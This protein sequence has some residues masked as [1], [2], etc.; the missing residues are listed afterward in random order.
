MSTGIPAD[1]HHQHRL[2]AHGALRYVTPVA[3][4]LMGLLFSLTGLNGFLH[5]LPE[6]DP[7]TF[8]AGVSAF[9]G[10]LASS[11]YMLELISGTQLLVGIL[12]VINLFVPLALVL[13]APVVVNIIAFHLFLM[14]AGTGLALVVVAMEVYL[15]W[16]YR[17]TYRPMLAA[18]TRPTE[19]DQ[20]TSQTG[21]IG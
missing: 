8:P 14:P 5:F 19:V 15:V 7:S 12:L 10:G 18:R 4:I 16:A 9:M 11:G 21:A 1:V 20:G 6:P 2:R 17:H 13:I 3:R